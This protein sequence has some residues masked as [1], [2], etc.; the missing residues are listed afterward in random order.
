MNQ[1]W[2]GCWWQHTG[3]G[4]VVLTEQHDVFVSAC[5][6]LNLW[7]IRLYHIQQGQK[8]AHRIHE[9]YFLQW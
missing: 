8:E 9:K 3:F 2:S 6:L 5:C 1:Y 7:V 4:H